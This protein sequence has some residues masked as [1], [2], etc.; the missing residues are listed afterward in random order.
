MTL[1][2]MDG[3]PSA[4]RPYGFSLHAFQ[5]DVWLGGKCHP[6]HVSG[7]NDPARDHDRHHSGLANNV[8]FMV[9]ADHMREQAGLEIIDL[10]TG[11][12]QAGNLDHCIIAELQPGSL[13]HVKEIDAA[14]GDVL[15]H[16]PRA[17][18][19]TIVGNLIEELSMDEMDLPQIR[20][21]RVPDDS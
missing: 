3:E 12:A 20:L 2:V 16:I 9:L 11:I 4:I 7:S 8:S 5:W 6:D 18:G 10:V 19:V 15:A 1:R 17:Y 21:I 13:G 14:S